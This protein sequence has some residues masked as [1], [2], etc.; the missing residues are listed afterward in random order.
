MSNTQSTGMNKLLLFVALALMCFGIVVVYSTSTPVALAKNLPPEYFLMKHLYKVVASVIIMGVFYKIDYALWKDMSRVVFGVGAVLTL[1]AIVSGGEVKGASRWIFGIQPSEIMKFGFICWVCAKLSNAGDEIKSIK[2]TIVQP[3]VPFAIS[4]LLLALQPNFSMLIMFAALLFTLLFI[5]GANYKYLFSG[6]GASIPLGLIVLLC[7]AHT[8]TRIKAFFSGDDGTMKESKR[9]LEHSLEALGNGG[10]FG[11][12]A[13]MGEQKLGYL[14][15]AHKDVVYAAIGEEFGFVVTFLVLVAFAILFSQ[16]FNIAKA[17]TTRFGRYMAVALT[18]SLFLNF[19]IHVCVCVG[20]FPTTGQPLPF[21]SFG[22][23]NLL[24]S[25]AFIG[26]MLNISR[27]TSGRSIREPYM[28]N[29]VS[30][31][32]S[33]FMSF[34]TRRSSI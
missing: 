24:M 29:T 5:A 3:A 25:S 32:A 8:S 15:E 2:C 30:F 28:N 13:G 10:L 31:D 21:L 33:S 17:S 23:T 6:L 19:A 20:L 11:T 18:T 14:P 7:K 26:I 27:P 34:R 12:G 4:A 16:G 22:G 1:A 9:Q